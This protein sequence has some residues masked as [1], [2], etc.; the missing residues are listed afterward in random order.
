MRRLLTSLVLLLASACGT[1]P[2]NLASG[3]IVLPRELREV[4]GIVA[5]DDRTIACVQDERGA[6]FFLDLLGQLPP[7]V[8]PFGA[9]GD[10]EGLARV[11][12]DFWVLR[13]DGLLVHLVPDGAG[14]R[15]QGSHRLMA[16]H[17]EY[18]G[19]CYDPVSKDLL[20]LPKDVVG[21]DKQERD[22]R[23]VFVFDLAAK[24][25]RVEP[26]LVL[27]ARAIAEQAVARTI[28]LPVDTTPKGKVR[29]TL[30]LHFSELA[31]IPGRR[32]L[33]MLSAVDAVLLR[34]DQTGQL[35]GGVRLD[36]SE[37]PQPEGLAFLPDGRLLVASE[38]AGGPGVLRVVEW[39]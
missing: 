29:S 9:P 17:Q 19:L 16:E 7:R 10:Y 39:R 26:L 34:V 23:P 25:L 28:D 5:I 11:G 8:V 4:S 15:V 24:K 12:E 32:E 20:V 21:K 6:L 18:E 38:G 14:L 37:L 33:L 3:A 35:L 36:R 1:R 31:M 22:E 13:S 27:S 2:Q 30:K